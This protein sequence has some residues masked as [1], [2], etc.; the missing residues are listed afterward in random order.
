[1]TDVATEAQA[2]IESATRAAGPS[3]LD[4]DGR[5]FSVVV[6]NDGKSVVIDLEEHREQ[7][8]ER[9]RRKRGTYQVHDA[10]SFVAYLHKHGDAGSEIWADTTA[11]KVT[12][13]LN[14]HDGRVDD[15]LDSLSGTESDAEARW[16]DHRVVYTVL[17]TD[18]WREWAALDGKLVDQA[19]FA[20]H[21]E[22]RAIDIIQPAAADML[23]LA[24]TFQATIGVNFESSKLL[25]SGERQLEY[26]ETVDGKAGKAGRMEIP[27]AFRIAVRPF[28]G[29]ETFAVTARFR[30]RITDGN[31]RFGFKLERPA[32]VLR[33]AFLSVVAAIDSETTQPVLRGAR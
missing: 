14:A 24:Q 29:A 8:L 25:S 2:V 28:E 11:A 1:M 13:V 18:A 6:P 15:V 30:Y 33:E 5:F 3:P 21:I 23:E 12:G 26:R 7:L 9:P 19:T 27:T 17:L 4:E 31:L 10:A 32:D 16:E 20:E 22:N